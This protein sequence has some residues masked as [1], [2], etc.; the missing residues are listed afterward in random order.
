MRYHRPWTCAHRTKVR[1]SLKNVLCDGGRSLPDVDKNINRC[2]GRPAIHATETDPTLIG[3]GIQ[4]FDNLILVQHANQVEVGPRAVTDIQ[5]TRG[6]VPVAGHRI[7]RRLVWARRS[8][9]D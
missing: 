2:P 7:R 9:G 8:L 5:D 3:T 1:Y 6:T 4:R